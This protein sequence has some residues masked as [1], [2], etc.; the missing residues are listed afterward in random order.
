MYHLT[1]K[2]FNFNHVTAKFSGMEHCT[3]HIY[4][5][6]YTFKLGSFVVKCQA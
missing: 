1:H 6:I 4:F 5:R 2:H 3:F